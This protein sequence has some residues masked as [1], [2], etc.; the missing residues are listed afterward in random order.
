MD[1][2]ITTLPSLISCYLANKTRQNGL[3]HLT[4]NFTTCSVNLLLF[5]WLLCPLRVSFWPCIDPQILRSIDRSR[6]PWSTTSP[7]TSFWDYIAVVKVTQQDGRLICGWISQKLFTSQSYLL[8]LLFC[9]LFII[10][11]WNGMDSRITTLPSLISCYLAN[12]TRQNGLV[13]LTLYSTTCSVNLLLFAWLLCPLR[14]SFWPTKVCEIA[15]P[16]ME[17][18]QILASLLFHHNSVHQQM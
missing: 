15:V 4:F 3:V 17:H 11:E 16:S 18:V 6:T 7:C 1:S 10:R 5:A 12:K 9:G 2:R 14:V 8:C 13:H